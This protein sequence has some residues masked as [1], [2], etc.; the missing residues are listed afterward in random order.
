MFPLRDTI[1]SRRVH[2]AVGAELDP[3]FTTFGT[4]VIRELS[5]SA[6]ISE[7]LTVLTQLKDI[8]QER[9]LDI[10]NPATVTPTSRVAGGVDQTFTGDGQLTTTITRNP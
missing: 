4:Q 5:S 2:D 6:T 1:P 10:L 9:G 8:W 3:I 7:I